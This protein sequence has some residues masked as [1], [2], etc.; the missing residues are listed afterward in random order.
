[1]CWIEEETRTSDFGDARLDARMK[2][3]L[4]ALSDKPTY[5]IPQAGGGWTETLAAYRFFDNDKV[6][7]EPVLHVHYDASLERIR[8]P[9]VVLLPQDTTEI[10]LTRQSS[11]GLGTLKKVE[12][13]ELFLHPVL[14]ITPGRIP[15]GVV[16][17]DLWVR[18]EN[19][20]R[21]DR[22]DKPIE[23]KESFRWIE[24]YQAACEIQ[25]QALNTLVV[26]LA[27]REGDM[28]EMFAEMNEYSPA[29]R[30]A[31]IIRSAQDRVLES[32]DP[33]ILKQGCKVEELQFADKKRFAACLAFYRHR[34]LAGIVC[35]D[36]G[37]RVSEY[38][39]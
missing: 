10:I 29:L 16:S 28:Y 4:K 20:I 9:P 18:P 25:S 31:W 30:A 33:E 12:K 34:G 38:R 19:S 35:N 15:L 39:L 26:M 17:M 1:M 2:K 27:D 6:S 32:D 7:F 37:A 24:G 11:L 36:A 3:I 8:Q 14:A 23:E 13:E 21:K 22:F 5:S